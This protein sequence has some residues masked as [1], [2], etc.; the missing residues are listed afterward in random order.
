MCVKNEREKRPGQINFFHF[1]QKMMM[2][3][4]KNIE[5]KKE[6]E[7]ISYCFGRDHIG[8]FL[9]LFHSFSVCL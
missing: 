5:K 2:M 3:E 6:T 9:S 7:Q 4:K 8:C 1:S